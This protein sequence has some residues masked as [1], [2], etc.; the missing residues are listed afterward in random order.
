MQFPDTF[1]EGEYRENFYVAP[2]MKRAWAAQLEVLLLFDEIC[3]AHGLRWYIG[4]GTLL[5]A[6]RHQ[7]F[8]P[9][10]DD[11]D[12][13]MFRNDMMKLN[14]LP[15]EVFAEKG[16]ILFNAYKDPHHTNLAWRVDNGRGL[17]LT[18]EHLLKYHLCPFA[19]GID[20][21]S[22]DVVPR[23]PEKARV[24]EVLWASANTL[25]HKHRRGE[26]AEEAFLKSYEKIERAAGVALAGDMSVEQRLMI[27]A[28][29]VQAKYGLE[30]GDK[31]AY[32]PW[33]Q[34]HPE[35]VYDP[36]WFGE[37]VYLPFEHLE[38]PAPCNPEQVLRADYGADYMTPQRTGA[39]HG[40]PFY[41]GQYEKLKR[42][43]EEAGEELP[44]FFRE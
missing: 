37:P 11:I 6:V 16:L 19:L 23:D 14:A 22:M 35:V 42:L 36:A 44:A 27:I 40:Y 26:I 38:L 43:F 5:G 32:L 21:F 30:D 29:M 39:A 3:E 15:D 31:V 2:M 18:E 7:G 8:I 12:L 1:F 25:F 17:N 41:K 20:L 33:T 9:W 28:D 10:D 24:Q 4:Y 34:T 13:V